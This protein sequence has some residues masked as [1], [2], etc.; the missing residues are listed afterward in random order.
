MPAALTVSV[1]EQVRGDLRVELG[2]VADGAG[3]VP[4]VGELV[5]RRHGDH[6]VAGVAMGLS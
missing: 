3:Q 4:A 6:D 5:K 1:A 2:R